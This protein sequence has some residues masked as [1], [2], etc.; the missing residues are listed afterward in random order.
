MALGLQFL[1]N[2]PFNRRVS[3]PARIHLRNFDGRSSTIE[4]S[5]ESEP[6]TGVEQ[7]LHARSHPFTPPYG[8]PH[9][10]F[11]AAPQFCSTTDDTMIHDNAVEPSTQHAQLPIY[12]TS[13]APM[14]PPSRT[15]NGEPRGNSQVIN[16]RRTSSAI[17]PRPSYQAARGLLSVN[18]N[19]SDSHPLPGLNTSQRQPESSDHVPLSG[20]LTPVSPRVSEALTKSMRI[21]VS[22]SEDNLRD[23]RPPASSFMGDQFTDPVRQSKSNSHSHL[24]SAQATLAQYYPPHLP[25]HNGYLLPLNASAENYLELHAYQHVYQNQLLLPR[26]TSVY[27]LQGPQ[28]NPLVRAP[29]DPTLCPAGFPQTPEM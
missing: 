10:E 22:V 15:V 25:I 20:C 3:S 5:P 1:S 7:S 6:S 23:H 18:G 28:P 2:E 14:S 12:S 13:P 21:Q 29:W 17:A 19:G 24:S 27:N 26:F 4:H 8:F 9:P 11:T 16:P